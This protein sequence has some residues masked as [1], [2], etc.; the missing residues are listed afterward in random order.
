MHDRASLRWRRIVSSACALIAVTAGITLLAGPAWGFDNSRRGFVLEFG[1]GPA[2]S[3][4]AKTEYDFDS[5]YS[6]PIPGSKLGPA[7]TTRL[8]IGGGVSERC[9]VT[10][11]YDIAWANEDLPGTDGS[12]LILNEISGVGVTVFARP[13]APSWL[14][15]SAIGWGNA[16]SLD[17]PSLDTSLGLQ[18]GAGYEFAQHWLTRFTVSRAFHDGIDDRWVLGVTMSAVLY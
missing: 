14:F 15:E 9:M 11:V 7:G 10:F 1:L 16:T 17:E 13:E 4:Q 8:R 6:V 12:E 3:S 18:V 5:G 2:I